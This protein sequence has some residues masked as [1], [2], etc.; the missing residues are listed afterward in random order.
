MQIMRFREAAMFLCM[1]ERSMR[2]YWIKWGI[3]GKKVGR[4]VLFSRRELIG[5]VESKQGIMTPVEG[6]DVSAIS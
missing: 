6:D 5:W 4:Q 2:E 3:P 1:N